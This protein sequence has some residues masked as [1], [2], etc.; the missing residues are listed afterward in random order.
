MEPFADIPLL[1]TAGAALLPV[2]MAAIAGLAAAVR[3]PRELIGLCREQPATAGGC[4]GAITTGIL[5]AAWLLTEGTLLPDC[6][7]WQIA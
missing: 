6:V 7:A 2:I 5:G 3:K 4:G 1:T